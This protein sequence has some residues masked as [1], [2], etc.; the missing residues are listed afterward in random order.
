MLDK[1]WPRWVVAIAKPDFPIAIDPPVSWPHA[2][3]G[4]REGWGGGTLTPHFTSLHSAIH[5]NLYSF[6]LN[7]CRCDMIG[8]KRKHQKCNPIQ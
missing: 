1:L 8:G 4:V 7:Q 3:G 5:S 2:G 6:V